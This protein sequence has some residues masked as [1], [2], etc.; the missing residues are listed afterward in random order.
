MCD[1]L[2]FVCIFDPDSSKDFQTAACVIF[3]DVLI[4]AT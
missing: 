2:K 1:V 3:I 4:Y